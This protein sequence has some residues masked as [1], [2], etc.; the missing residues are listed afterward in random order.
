MQWYACLIVLTLNGNQ[1]QL[2][3]VAFSPDG[4]WLGTTGVD[5]ALRLWQVELPQRWSDEH[6]LLEPT[7]E[8]T[9]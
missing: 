7:L 8:G 5:G 9:D 4:R 1:N 3:R 6:L 2:Y